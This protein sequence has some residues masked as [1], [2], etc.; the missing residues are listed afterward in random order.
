MRL[1][2]CFYRFFSY[3]LVH[4]DL[5]EDNETLIERLASLDIEI[6]ELQDSHAETE[7][8][9]LASLNAAEERISQEADRAIEAETSLAVLKSE[10]DG[11]R[12]ENFDLLARIEGMQRSNQAT[13]AGL[14]HREGEVETL[15]A[16]LAEERERSEALEA[17]LDDAKVH[18]MLSRHEVVLPDPKDVRIA[19]LEG[20]VAELRQQA[21]STKARAPS[22]PSSPVR[23]G[24]AP[25][26]RN[27]ASPTSAARPRIKNNSPVKQKDEQS[28]LIREQGQQITRLQAENEM[29][30]KQTA[31]AMVEL[32]K[33]HD[34]VRKGLEE[35]VMQMESV[36]Q[37]SVADHDLQ[38]QAQGIANL[39]TAM[40]PELVSMNDGQIAPGNGILHALQNRLSNATRQM[41]AMRREHER[42]MRSMNTERDRLEASYEAKLVAAQKDK[43]R[44]LED[45]TRDLKETIE[46]LKIELGEVRG[47][48]SLSELQRKAAE[49][50]L[51]TA[52][53]DTSGSTEAVLRIA[54]EQ[55][56]VRERERGF[57][58]EIRTLRSELD[59]ERRRTDTWKRKAAELGGQLA[60]AQDLREK[61]HQLP[62]LSRSEASGLRAEVPISANGQTSWSE[63]LE[64]LS[65]RIAE[66]EEKFTRE[67]SG[68]DDIRLSRSFR[69][70]T[71]APR[72]SKSLGPEV[73]HV[74]SR[75][76]DLSMELSI[77]ED[78]GFSMASESFLTSVAD[79]DVSRRWSGDF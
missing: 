52:W 71:A 19:E 44:T 46:A 34:R 8:Q 43:L 42:E 70:N 55:G 25:T 79:E 32:K 38:T 24:T 33:E 31:D 45:Q 29:L 4:R 54:K 76:E 66:L 11:L 26:D 53:R 49:E 14:M 58:N 13:E 48:L 30:V 51:E 36:L 60:S 5:R 35:K 74:R 6:N 47:Q 10:I 57:Q 50:K 69:A 65:R 39:P 64:K 20:L 15:R 59:E 3:K 28:Q 37:Q 56:K 22:A 72:L 77:L 17:E 7:K 62:P 1:A 18:I 63:K 68:E 9:L 21:K 75:W 40:Y 78:G 73:R 61:H 27:T 2:V 23:G 67:D 41:D 12:R 16:K